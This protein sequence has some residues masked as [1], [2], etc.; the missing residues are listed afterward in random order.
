MIDACLQELRSN[1]RNRRGLMLIESKR[2]VKNFDRR[3]E[4]KSSF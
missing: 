2:T 3:M 4:V 1:H